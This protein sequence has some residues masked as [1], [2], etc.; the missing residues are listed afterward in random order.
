MAKMIVKTGLSGN[1]NSARSKWCRLVEKVANKEMRWEVGYAICGMD[2]L[3]RKCFSGS[4]AELKALLKNSYEKG[5]RLG[6]GSGKGVVSV[7]IDI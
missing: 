1:M 6:R 4:D 3:L 7:E 2:E 5:E